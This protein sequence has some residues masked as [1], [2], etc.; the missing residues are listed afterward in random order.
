MTSSISIS[1]SCESNTVL[2]TDTS[3]LP[4][5]SRSKDDAYLTVHAALMAKIEMLAS[6]NAA[7][8]QKYPQQKRHLSGWKM[9]CMMIT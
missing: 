4:S 9:L 6:E 1:S 3:Q 8:K 7:L 5:T 2:S